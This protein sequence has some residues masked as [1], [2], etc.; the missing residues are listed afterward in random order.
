MDSYAIRLERQMAE[1]ARALHETADGLVTYLES[2]TEMQ[3]ILKL[4]NA[5]GDNAR[6]ALD[7]ARKW[8]ARIEQGD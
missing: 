5:A 1:A 4:D 3:R 6:A 2:S 7:N 8:R